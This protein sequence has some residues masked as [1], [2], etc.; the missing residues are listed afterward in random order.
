MTLDSTEQQSGALRRW[1]DEQPADAAA[2][3]APPVLH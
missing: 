1:L 3:P 2:V